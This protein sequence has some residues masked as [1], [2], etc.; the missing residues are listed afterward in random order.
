MSSRRSTPFE[1]ERS[2]YLGYPLIVTDRKITVFTPA[3]RKITEV[4][5]VKQARLVVRGYRRAEKAPA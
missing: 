2:S 5:S 4:S 3:L 1:A